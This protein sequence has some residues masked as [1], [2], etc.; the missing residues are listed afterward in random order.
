MQ[1]TKNKAKRQNLCYKNKGARVFSK[2]ILIRLRR[3]GKRLN[4]TLS[5]QTLIV[6]RKIDQVLSA[7]HNNT[8][9]AIDMW[10]VYQQA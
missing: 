1:I 7:K 6:C 8:T 2:T 4:G 10:F 5:Y 3:N 9:R